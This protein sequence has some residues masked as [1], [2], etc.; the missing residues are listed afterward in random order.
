MGYMLH[1]VDVP[2]GAKAQIFLPHMRHVLIRALL[3]SGCFRFS[4]FTFVFASAPDRG[5]RRIRHLLCAPTG[6]IL[7]LDCSPRIA[8]CLSWAIVRCPSGTQLFDCPPSQTKRAN[9]IGT[10]PYPAAGSSGKSLH[11]RDLIAQYGNPSP[12]CALHHSRP[13]PLSSDTFLAAVSCP[14]AL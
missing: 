1:L 14:A 3:Q 5:C 13:T 6:L 9:A 12:P 11:Y 7:L 2:S 4:C 10:T 8:L